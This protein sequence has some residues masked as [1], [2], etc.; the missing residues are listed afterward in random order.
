MFNFKPLENQEALAKLMAKPKWTKREGALIYCGI[1]PSKEHE[2]ISKDL[3]HSQGN[4]NADVRDANDIVTIWENQGLP[5]EV[6]PKD[7]IAWIKNQID[8]YWLEAPINSPPPLLDFMGKPILSKSLFNSPQRRP[9]RAPPFQS[10]SLTTLFHSSPTRSAST[11]DAPT[12]TPKSSSGKP[13]IVKLERSLTMLRKEHIEKVLQDFPS[14]LRLI[15]LAKIAWDRI[16]SD[17][18][19]SP[20]PDVKEVID[21]PEGIVL[22]GKEGYAPIDLDR[23]RQEISKSPIYK[24]NARFR[25]PRTP[26]KE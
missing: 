22:K 9:L 3:W 20:P 15:D 1:H 24:A 8:P 16:L 14:S 2:S 12:I 10:N 7:F 23:I 26:E 25:K 19:A 4:M 17:V 13:V 11:L 5:S 6:A 21:D 18:K